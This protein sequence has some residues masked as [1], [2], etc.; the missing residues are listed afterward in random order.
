MQDWEGYVKLQINSES[1]TVPDPGTG[2]LRCSAFP[3]PCEIISQG[4]SMG[5]SRRPH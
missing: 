5:V 2:M 4:V 1:E 3:A